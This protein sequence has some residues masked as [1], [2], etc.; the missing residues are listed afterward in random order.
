MWEFVVQLFLGCSDATCVALAQPWIIALF[1]T[2]IEGKKSSRHWYSH[3]LYFF[4]LNKSDSYATIAGRDATPYDNMWCVWGPARRDGDGFCSSPILQN[5]WCA[6]LGLGIWHSLRVFILG[7]TACLQ[8]N[9]TLMLVH[10]LWGFGLCLFQLVGKSGVCLF[11]LVG[12]SGARS[13]LRKEFLSQLRNS[14]A[15]T[16]LRF[17]YHVNTLRTVRVI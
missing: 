15:I 9:I 8:A 3:M 7:E 10:V 4:L 2:R 13:S 6:Y 16:R 14:A 1:E 11:Q 12:K 5:H 17:N